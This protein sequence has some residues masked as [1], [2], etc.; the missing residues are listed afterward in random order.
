MIHIQSIKL[1]INIKTLQIMPINKNA[2]IRY[3]ALD[4]CLQNRQ[5]RFYIQDLIDACNAALASV[6]G[7]HGVKGSEG[8]SLRQVYDDLNFMEDPMGF[9]VTIERFKEGRKTFYRYAEDSKTIKEQ[10]IKQEEIDMIHDALMLLR[11]FEGIPQFEW[12]D[13][14][15]TN[16]YTTSKLGTDTESVVSFQHNPYLKGM[17]WYRPLFDAIISHRMIRLDYQPFGKES[18]TVKVSPYHLKQ[19]NNRWFLIARQEDCTY[20]SNYAI[21]RILNIAELADTFI[22]LDEGFSFKDYFADVVGVSVTN[23]PVEKVVLHVTEKALGYIV[24][25]PLHESQ[26]SKPEPLTDGRWRITL[27]AKENY[28]LMSLLRSF[29]DGVEVV[30]PPSLRAKMKEMAGRMAEMYRD[31]SSSYTSDSAACKLPPDASR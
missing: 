13:D 25:K 16:L 29:G 7:T 17:K 5:K 20:L 2:M 18:R 9:G 11:R 30:Q 26:S 8:V 14:L 3:K 21:D 10:P 23:S 1:T 12:L 22:P 15:E 6:N 24:T 4:R 19:Y 31:F 27:E 28:E